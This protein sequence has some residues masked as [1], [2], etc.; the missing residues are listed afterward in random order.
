MIQQ[1]PGLDL[2]RPTQTDDV[3]Q[4]DVPRTSFA[5]WKDAKQI[6]RV[7]KGTLQTLKS[8]FYAVH[9]PQLL[10]ARVLGIKRAI[11]SALSLAGRRLSISLLFIRLGE[12]SVLRDCFRVRYQ[13]LRFLEG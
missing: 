4:A 12:K 9:M 8:S 7:T 13:T 6:H 10:F 2:Q 5:I 3:L 1:L 11:P